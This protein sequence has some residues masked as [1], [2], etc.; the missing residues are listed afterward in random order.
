MSQRDNFNDDNGIT[1]ADEPGRLS[2][3]SLLAGRPLSTYGVFIAGIGVLAA[4]L[5]ILIVTTRGDVLRAVVQK[6]RAAWPEVV[7]SVRGDSGVAVPAVSDCCEQ[8]QL[9][10]ALGYATNAVRERCVAQ[11]TADGET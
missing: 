7:I 1:R 11:A 10:Y 2:P 6:L 5:G 4:L 9:H 8:E 3:R